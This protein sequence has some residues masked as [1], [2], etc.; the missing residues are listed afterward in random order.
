MPYRLPLY[1]IFWAHIFCKYGGWGWSDLFSLTARQEITLRKPLL[2]VSRLD[3]SIRANQF[4]IHHSGIPEMNPF[5]AN[6]VSGLF[7]ESRTASQFI[8]NLGDS[9]ANLMAQVSGDSHELR[10]R[11]ENRE[12]FCKSIRANGFA[13]IAQIRVANRSAI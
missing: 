8:R 3:A 7:C 11:C 12:F 9:N 10:K 1:G 4:H 13:R 5:F 2:F 6:R